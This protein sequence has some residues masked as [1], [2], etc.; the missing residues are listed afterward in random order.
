MT[1][2]ETAAIATMRSPYCI[3]QHCRTMRHGAATLLLIRDFPTAA[4]HKDDVQRRRLLKQAEYV[5]HSLVTA[6][7][8]LF[9]L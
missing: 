3:L 9:S 6:I 8:R 4:A 7:I 2:R 5:L 1:L